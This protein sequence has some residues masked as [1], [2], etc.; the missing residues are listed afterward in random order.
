MWSSLLLR[1]TTYTLIVI[2]TFWFWNDFPAA[3]ADS[4]LGAAS[5]D[6]HRDSFAYSQ[7]IMQWDLALPALMMAILPASSRFWPCRKISSPD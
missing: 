1:P 2:N 6:P 4:F 5:H 7:Y 3:E